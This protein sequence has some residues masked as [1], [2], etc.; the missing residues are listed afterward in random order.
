MSCKA[1]TATYDELCTKLRKI[2]HLEGAMGLM[3][4]DEQTMVRDER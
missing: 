3:G 4:W 1:V 2:A